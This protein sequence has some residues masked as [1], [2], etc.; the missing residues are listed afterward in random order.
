MSSRD[1]SILIIAVFIFAAIV[2]SEFLPSENTPRI[3]TKSDYKYVAQEAVKKQLK[4]P[5]TAEFSNVTAYKI[6]GEGYRVDGL[7]DSQNLFGA[8]IRS[9]WTVAVYRKGDNFS[10]QDLRI[11]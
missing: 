9:S 7:V 6:S 8:M 3:Y 2:A 10:Y 4:S 11:N 1:K 5:A